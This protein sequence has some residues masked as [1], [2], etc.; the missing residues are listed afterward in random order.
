MMRQVVGFEIP[1]ARL[2]AKAKQPQLDLGQFLIR[3]KYLSDRHLQSLKRRLVEAE[4]G[5]PVNRV[6]HQWCV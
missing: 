6:E 3:K 1:I 4:V 5:D 2:E